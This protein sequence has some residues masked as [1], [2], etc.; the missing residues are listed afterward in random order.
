[1]NILSSIFIGLAAIP[2]VLFLVV[3]MVCMFVISLPLLLVAGAMA[4]VEA[5]Y[6]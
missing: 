5:F 4:A 1:M 2:L 3:I 6:D